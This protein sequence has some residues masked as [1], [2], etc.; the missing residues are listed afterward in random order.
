METSPDKAKKDQGGSL[1][2]WRILSYPLEAF[3]A[4]IMVKIRVKGNLLG[5]R[6][7]IQVLRLL[8]KRNPEC[9]PFLFI[10]DRMSSEKNK[11]EIKRYCPSEVRL[12]FFK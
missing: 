1:R 2:Y 6:K 11:A 8:H 7:D 5:I 10:C 12:I 4:A 3:R 9:L